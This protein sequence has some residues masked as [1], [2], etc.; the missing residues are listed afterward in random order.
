M[1]YGIL[2][3][4]QSAILAGMALGLPTAAAHAIDEKAMQNISAR[5]KT[6]EAKLIE[7]SA[8]PNSESRIAS[9]HRYTWF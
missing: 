4:V 3:F 1:K 5:V 7:A 6:L 2:K 9:A 8:E